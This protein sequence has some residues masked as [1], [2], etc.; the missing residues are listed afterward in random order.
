MCLFRTFQVPLCVCEFIWVYPRWVDFLLDW[1]GSH[2]NSWYAQFYSST[3][4]PSTRTKNYLQFHAFRVWLN[5]LYVVGP[6]SMIRFQCLCSLCIC[7]GKNLPNMFQ[8]KIIIEL[9]MDEFFFIFYG[10][11]GM[12][13]SKSFSFMIYN[14][15]LHCIIRMKE[16]TYVVQQYKNT[17]HIRIFQDDHIFM[18]E[19]KKTW[20]NV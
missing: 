2:P 10:S 13:P 16:I 17:T 14:H 19:E 1:I 9:K 5:L 4:E 18:H 3:C 20:T 8:L 11:L 6:I 15:Y 12:T 7:E